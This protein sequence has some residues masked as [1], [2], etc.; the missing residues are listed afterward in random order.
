MVTTYKML[1]LFSILLFSG[2]NKSQ[3]VLNFDLS[4]L[5]MKSGSTRNFK[6][7]TKN[8]R[9]QGT[10][11]A[12]LVSPYLTVASKLYLAV[13]KPKLIQLFEW[14]KIPGQGQG[15]FRAQNVSK[16]LV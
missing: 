6:R 16:T 11:G 1:Q 15:W 7:K 3:H 8:E 4:T 5:T 13:Y 10:K 9:V 12:L 14:I 2:K